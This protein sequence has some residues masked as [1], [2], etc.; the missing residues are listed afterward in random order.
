MQSIILHH[1]EGS[2]GLTGW[3]LLCCAIQQAQ[4]PLSILLLVR[5]CIQHKS[6]ESL[7]QFLFHSNDSREIHR[8]RLVSTVHSHTQFYMMYQYNYC[9][10]LLLPGLFH[11]VNLLSTLLPAATQVKPNHLQHISK[12]RRTCRN[13]AQPVH[14][15]FLLWLSCTMI[16]LF[17]R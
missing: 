16:P 14:E 2:L 1:F 13:T 9:F 6:Q 15:R 5:L 7:S 12:T 11:F 3:C 17:T 4:K 10:S 8:G